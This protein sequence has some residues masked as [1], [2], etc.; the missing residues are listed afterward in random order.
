[1]VHSSYQCKIYSLSISQF[2]IHSFSHEQKFLS[3]YE[4][5]L[6][7]EGQGADQVQSKV[8]RIHFQTH[9]H[10][11]WKRD[12]SLKLVKPLELTFISLKKVF[13]GQN[14]FLYF[15]KI[16]CAILNITYQIQALGT[17]NF[18]SNIINDNIA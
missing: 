18:F 15:I 9:F 4:Q 13:T 3:V 7:G 6:C 10:K 11:D 14:N 17:A 12:R 1:M 8:K 2:T 16:D 5:S